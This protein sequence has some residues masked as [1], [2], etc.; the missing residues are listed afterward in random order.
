MPLRA[1][2]A[3]FFY[4]AGTV[5]FTLLAVVFT[6]SLVWTLIALAIAAFIPIGLLP[7]LAAQHRRKFTSQLPDMAGL[8][9]K[10]S[11]S[12]IKLYGIPKSV[13]KEAYDDNPDARQHVRDS[14]RKVRNLCVELGIITPVSKLLWKGFGIWEE[15]AAATAG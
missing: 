15:P 4:I 11:K 9:L 14:L 3:L 2:E 10:P 6:R 5:V 1:A 12:A 13:I 7:G 8:M